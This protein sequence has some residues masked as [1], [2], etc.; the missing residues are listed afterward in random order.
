VYSCGER[1]SV[2]EGELLAFGGNDGCG[3]EVDSFATLRNDSQKGKNNSKG[4]SNGKGKGNGNSKAN[5]EILR[6]A[7]G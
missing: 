4:N 5:T 1:C 2:R 7:L 6:F 3:R